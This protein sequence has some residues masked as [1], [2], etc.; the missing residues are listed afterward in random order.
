MR[1]KVEYIAITMIAFAL[2]GYLNIGFEK[3]KKDEKYS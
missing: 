2:I 3:T 1:Y